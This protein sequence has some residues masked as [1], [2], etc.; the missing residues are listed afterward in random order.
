MIRQANAEGLEPVTIAKEPADSDAAQ[1]CL[2][3]YFELLNE[4]F[5]GG[6]D[7][8]DAAPADAALFTPPDGIFLL[9]KSADKL[10]G[11]GGVKRNAPGIGEIKR[12]WVAEYA[13]GLGLGQ[14]LLDALEQEAR[15]LGFHSIRL[16]TNKSLTEAKALYLKNGYREI[17]PYNEDPYPDFY[18]EKTLV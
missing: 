1:W 5:E 2:Q 18:F 8:A 14:R 11:C 16:D 4:R 13:R 12:L 3:R 17:P 15:K 10:L 7:P 9:A 6:Y